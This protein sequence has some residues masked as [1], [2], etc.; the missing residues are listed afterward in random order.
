MKLLKYEIAG[1]GE[2]LDGIIV[3]VKTAKITRYEDQ[4]YEIVRIDQ[5]N[6]LFDSFSLPLSKGLLIH[7]DKLRSIPT[8]KDFGT[9]NPFGKFISTNRFERDNIVVDHVAYEKG[10]T[11][12]VINEEKTL[13]SHFFT[14]DKSKGA[15]GFVQSSFVTV[16]Y[17]IDN[18]VFDLRD[19]E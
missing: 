2:P 11:V 6:Q 7:E 8:R 1:M 17:D 18:F 10:C 16:D 3:H 15:T 13:Y 4:Y 9:D 5:P 12:T 14:G 19:Y